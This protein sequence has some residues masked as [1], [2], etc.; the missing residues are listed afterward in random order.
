MK[1]TFL[2]T[3]AAGFCLFGTNNVFAEEAAKAKPIRVIE[4]PQYS[5]K[6]ESI[7]MNFDGSLDREEVESFF[8]KM[9]DVKNENNGF[10]PRLSKVHFGNK[11]PEPKPVVI[12]FSKSDFIKVNT[13]KVFERDANANGVVV[14]SEYQDKN[15]YNFTKEQCKKIIKK[16]KQPKSHFERITADIEGGE[17]SKVKYCEKKYSLK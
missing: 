8:G 9:F 10:A 11:K 14:L 5:V 6:Y 1:Y 3:V 4:P 17:T 2:L 12:E 13:D 15:S 16:S 7:D